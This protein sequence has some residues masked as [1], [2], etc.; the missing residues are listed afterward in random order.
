MI[1]AARLHHVDRKTLS[2]HVLFSVFFCLRN[3]DG[4][5]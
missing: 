3:M 4:G 1:G 5:R 2:L